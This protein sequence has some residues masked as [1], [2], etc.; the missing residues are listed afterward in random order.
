MI[1]EYMN[2]K[3]KALHTAHLQRNSSESFIVKN[4][5]SKYRQ[6]REGKAA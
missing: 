4:R 6:E 1:R 3:L 5:L 2:A